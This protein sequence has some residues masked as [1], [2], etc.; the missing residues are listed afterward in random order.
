MVEPCAGR[1][2]LTARTGR[3]T[4]VDDQ[5]LVLKQAHEMS[6]FLALSHTDLQ[7]HSNSSSYMFDEG[8]GDRHYKE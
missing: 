8:R 5:R 7:R 1:L 4:E 2:A 6:W 3:P